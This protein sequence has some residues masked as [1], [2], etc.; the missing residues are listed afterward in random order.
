[1]NKEKV[2]NDSH[3]VG[4]VLSDLA[5]DGELFEWADYPTNIDGVR[6]TVDEFCDVDWKDGGKYSY[7]QDIV[8][9][10]PYYFAQDVTRYGSYF[11]GYDYE[12]DS[13]VY[14]VEP[15]ETIIVKYVKVSE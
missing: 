11:S 14:E 2:Y 8:K 6:I 3:G 10:G 4:F 15:V 9:I 5:T 12:V 1:M 7:G 13:S